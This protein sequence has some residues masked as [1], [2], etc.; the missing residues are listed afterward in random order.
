MTRTTPTVSFGLYAMVIKQDST[1]SCD[2]LQPF[3]KINDLRTDNATSRPYATYE[4]DYWLL[5]GGYKFI[6][7]D[8]TTVHVGL[9]SLSMSGSAGDFADPPELTIDFSEP[10][11]SD[12][13][14]LRFAEYSSDWADSIH[15]AFYDS[16]GSTLIT[17]DDYAPDDWE[18]ST[19]DTVTDYQKIVITFN[20]TNKPYR[21][22]RVTGI[23]YGELI[24]FT[25]ADIQ[26][27]TVV[28][29]IDPISA[30]VPTNILELSLYSDSA[31]FAII[32]P[33][34]DYSAL[35]YRQ[36]LAV[37]ENVGNDKFFIGQFYLDDWDAISDTSMIF[38]AVDM[39]GVLDTIPYLGGLW[40]SGSDT[41]GDIIEAMFAAIS[42]PYDLAPDIASVVVKGWIPACSYREAL[43]QIAFAAGAYVT[44]SR[45]GLVQ[46]YETV[47]ASGLSSAEYTITKAQKG[48][49]QTLT[50]KTLVTGVEVT[51]HDY[52]ANTETSE[53]YNGTLAAGTY[54]ITFNAPMHDLSATGA[55]IAASGANYATLTVAS[56]G[57][58]TLSGQGY[59]DTRRVVG[60]YDATLD[61][62]VKTNILTIADATLVCSDNVATVA[63]RVYDYYQQRYTQKVKLFAPSAAAGNSVLVDTLYSKQI[64]GI[65]EK[66]D[67]NLTGGYIVKAEITGV[68]AT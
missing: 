31:D 6:P 65:V 42:T 56:G 30:T 22:L 35:Q 15:V 68:V 45:A 20:A 11:T 12:G 1:P 4:P 54:T 3:A 34:G 51:A 46:I 25:G 53:L 63:Q 67:I 57:V 43:Q 36:P 18:F 26:E 9:M 50:L 32:S 5:D 61:T 27:A 33:A 47:L 59:T 48:R 41:V 2:D 16:S 40:L 62:Y 13:I 44:C 29:Q 37:Y 24:T 38:H 10:H 19:E 55:T 23:D 66:M 21:Y 8:T 28:E 17:E 60:V 58:V 14:T 7:D 64:L 52:V 49:D 39:I